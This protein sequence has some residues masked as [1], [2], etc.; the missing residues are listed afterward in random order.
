MKDKRTTPAFCRDMVLDALENNKKAWLHLVSLG[1]PLWTSVAIDKSGNVK[2][3]E[4][5]QQNLAKFAA[6][7]LINYAIVNPDSYSKKTMNGVA[8][9]L[10]RLGL[11]PYSSS[12]LASRVVADFMA[13]L[14]Y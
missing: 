7:K 8:S 14:C 12:A 9:V 5:Q 10:C 13:I 11:R 3:D 2:T 6:K 1:R 4:V